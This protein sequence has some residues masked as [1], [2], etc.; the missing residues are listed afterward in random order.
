MPGD[1]NQSTQLD[2]SDTIYADLLE[3]QTDRLHGYQGRNA[4]GALSDMEKAIAEVE[5]RR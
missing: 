4:R 5:A 3:A 2:S 1:T